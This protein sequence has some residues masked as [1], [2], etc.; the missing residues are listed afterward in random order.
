MKKNQKNT[1]L[2]KKHARIKL[3]KGK[4]A[5]A[6]K[7]Y[8]QACEKNPQDI[9][10][11][12][13]LAGI[14]AQ[15]GNI[16]EVI[17]CCQ[18]QLHLQPDNAQ[19]HYNI[20][21][22]YQS[23]KQI[24]K[25]IEHYQESL[26]LQ[27]DHLPSMT[28]LAIALWKQGE[29]NQ[30]EQLCNEILASNQ[31]LPTVVN[32]LGLIYRDNGDTEKAEAYFKRAI[33]QYP[34]Q[35]ELY[36]NL[37]E[38][39]Q[40]KD[41]SLSLYQQALQ[42]DPESE[43]AH[44]AIANIFYQNGDCALALQHYQKAQ[45]ISPDST[46]THFNLGRTYYRMDN[47]TDAIKHY[48]LVLQKLPNHINTLNNLAQIYERTG[49]TEQAHTYYIKAL[50][51][52][53]DNSAILTHR[54]ELFLQQED[55]N[56]SVEPFI[57]AIK[58]D[59]DNVNA[60]VGLAMAYTELGQIDKA[61]QHYERAYELDPDSDS[62]PYY[63]EGVQS[64]SA[65][66]KDS[67]KHIAGLFDKY[68]DT[69][70]NELFNKLDYK[71]PHLINDYLRDTLDTTKQKY[72]I[73]DLGCGTGICGQLTRDIAKRLVGID[74]SSN[75]IKKAREQAKYNELIVGEQISCMA[76]YKEEFDIVLS[77]DVFIYVGDLDAS[78]RAIKEVLRDSGLLVFSTEIIDGDSFMLRS[79]GRYA[80][81]YNY[82]KSLSDQYGYTLLM[83]QDIPLRKEYTR[84]I[85][86]AI[87]ALQK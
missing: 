36:I 58:I 44:S 42:K 73:L 53:P 72:D 4:L 16:P 33:K 81:S 47:N 3:K 10:A 28:N 13:M 23:V 60:Y 83:H 62:I 38:I 11:W 6:E 19:A 12:F 49:N 25:A 24:P 86:G 69:F 67:N 50:A 5:D 54:A 84:V 31:K 21:C 70:D 78:F 29:L 17:Q 9:E 7:L 48:Q 77:T 43:L 1:S 51:I 79:S 2:L 76:T 45:K 80:H 56:Q 37:A 64:G 34:Q 87:Y 18:Q 39:V 20:A 75:M 55:Y 15:T 32:C 85:Q 71:A 22:A 40:D 41:L 27:P 35:I 68:A 52:E 59:P 14:H 65:T 46:E 74:L 26:K 61:I 57:H 30:A 66:S 82:I 8:T 63:I